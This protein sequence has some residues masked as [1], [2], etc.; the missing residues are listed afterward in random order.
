MKAG[1]A[2]EVRGGA[3]AAGGATAGSA[4][5]T[6]SPLWA[7]MFAEDSR[8]GRP[9]P[10]KRVPR[11]ASAQAL[12]P[13]SP[14]GQVDAPCGGLT[15]SL[16][17][18]GTMGPRPRRLDVS[19]RLPPSDTLPPETDPALRQ[20]LLYLGSGL[21]AAGEAVNEIQVH[22]EV[23]STQQLRGQ[24]RL[25]QTAAPLR[26]AQE[27][28]TRR[29]PACGRRS[30][31]ARDH[32]HQPALRSARD[33]S[34]TCGAADGS[35]AERKARCKSKEVD[36]RTRTGDPFITSYGPLSPSVTRSHLRSRAAP[37]STDWRRGR[38]R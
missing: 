30:P 17:Q 5:D 8:A 14:I 38:G 35:P 28:R 11:L 15:I 20:F 19:V 37:N 34:R 27:G 23:E 24:L 29:G 1:P 9:D 7:G 4:A 2:T 22:A 6:T 13:G 33:H 18:D 16:L 32:L 36:A 21:T 10:L 25:D 31:G 3:T 12:A 26:A